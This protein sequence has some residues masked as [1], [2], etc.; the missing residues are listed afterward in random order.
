MEN[1]NSFDPQDK[2]LDEF[3]SSIYLNKTNKN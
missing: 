1:E 3:H 2:H